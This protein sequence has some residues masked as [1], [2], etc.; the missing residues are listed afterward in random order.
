MSESHRSGEL[1][2]TD[3]TL[4]GELAGTRQ[5][6]AKARLIRLERKPDDEPQV[7]VS[8]L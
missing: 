2:A 3:L 1:T 7:V 8:W 6:L 5:V 4:A